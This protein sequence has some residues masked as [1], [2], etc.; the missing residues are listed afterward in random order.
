MQIADGAK[1]VRVVSAAIVDDRETEVEVRMAVAFG[2]PFEV[3]LK[4]GI[5]HDVG[6]I[7]IADGRDV[8]QHVFHHRLAGDGQ[9]RLGLIECQWIKARGVTCGQDD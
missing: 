8:V 4:L 5:R 3:A 6:M 7:D 1:L 2:P 9:Q